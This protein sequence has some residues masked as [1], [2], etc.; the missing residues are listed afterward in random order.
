MENRLESEELRA[1]HYLSRQTAVPLRQ[2]LQDNLLTPHLSTIISLPNSGLDTMI[3][4]DKD[5]MDNL[6]RLYRLFTMVPTGLPC[7]KRSLKDSIANRGKEVNRLSL[8]LDSGDIDVE[9]DGVENKAENASRKGKGKTRTPNLIV[10]T[11]SLALRWVQDILDLKDKFDSIWKQA[12]NNDRELESALNEVGSVSR[13]MIKLAH[14]FSVYRLSNRLLM[15][16]RRHPNSFLC[17]LMTT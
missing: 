17:S 2:I 1:H 14:I 7:L 3:D 4:S 16:T 10:Q 11:L 5:N 6:A 13:R 9:G 15:A 8:G 12:F